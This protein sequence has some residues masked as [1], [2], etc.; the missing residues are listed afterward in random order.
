VG[1]SREASDWITAAASVPFDVAPAKRAEVLA[2][3]A[4]MLLD[5]ARDDIASRLLDQSLASRE[6]AGETPH[7]STLLVLAQRA[8]VRNESEESSR[9]CEAAVAAARSDGDPYHLAEAL[10]QASS[11]LAVATGD[12]RAAELADEGLAI[13]RRLGNRHL[14]A[15]CLQG[16]GIANV[17]VDPVR[18]VEWMTESLAISSRSA[19][20]QSQNHF[21][22]SLAHLRLRDER[23]AAR[24][25][26][27]A[28]PMMQERGEPY[29]ES[30]A[31]AL[32][33][34]VLA[35]RDP[36]LAVRTLALIDR[37]R[38]EEQFVGA[39]ADIESQQ[40][41]R[42][43]LEQRLDREEFA[44]LWAEGRAMT[45]DDAIASTLDELA[46]LAVDV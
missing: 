36:S 17:R 24:S 13:A 15:Y 32:A 8:L 35:R 46:G 14:L 23:A 3:A 38:E 9:Y 45:L 10:T 37:L 40:Q 30:M 2:L 16:G 42:A 31:L 18:A 27:S 43:R 28:L 33:A 12:V 22:M 5:H 20:A 1:L 26:C 19:T 41:L 11:F 39:A 6:E 34:I 25:L 7:P 4:Q 21:W 29:Y 44:E